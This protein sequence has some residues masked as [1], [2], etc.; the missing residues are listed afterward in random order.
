M[1]K[2]LYVTTASRTIN[3]FLVP[4]IEMLLGKGYKVECA[5]SID[6]SIDKRLLAKGVKIYEVQFSRN[7]LSIINFKAY[8]RLLDIQRINNY[9][10]IH[11]HTYIASIYGRFI[12]NT[13]QDVKIIY[14]S[15]GYK[16]SKG[17]SK[18]S[19]I[20]DYPMEKLMSMLTDVT[21]NT[22]S[23]DYDI[24]KSKLKQKKCYLINGVGLNL[25]NY[26]NTTEEEKKNKRIELGLK[27]DDFV[28]MMIGELNKNKNHM[29]LI[30]S[31][32]I[33]KDKYPRIKAITVGYGENLEYLKEQAKKRG[34]EKNIIF[35]GLR[36]D[37]N[38]LINISD[39]GVLLSYKEG[40][41][42]DLMKFMAN[43]R[44][45]IATNIRGCKDIVWNENIGTLVNVGDYER[46]AKYI[47]KY[48]LENDKEFKVPDEI[49]E[50]DVKN[51]VEKLSEVYE[52]IEWDDRP[53]M[54]RRLAELHKGI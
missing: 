42:R 53:G 13:F 29:Q 34:V 12:K 43:G 31:L 10:I 19:W 44:K 51:I 7:P 14:T 18:I 26:E 27:D 50:Y 33:L 5:C 22:N 36:E 6:K 17:G 16:F 4:H 32:E 47:E 2:I 46:T 24:S 20:I 25:K 37:V 8:R 38:E 11:L 35:L 23:E 28:V 45:V 40:L 21:I 30:K 1:K 39:I 52:E 9:D 41:P 3:A 54:S 48:F 49:K 15:Y